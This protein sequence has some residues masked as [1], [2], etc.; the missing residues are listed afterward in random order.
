MVPNQNFSGQLEL[1]RGLQNRTKPHQL[2]HQPHQ[3]NLIGQFYFS[4][5]HGCADFYATIMDFLHSKK[6]IPQHFQMN[7]NKR[8]SVK[9]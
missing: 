4:H 2:F 9:N 8:S 1:D 5:E 3:L 7:L 6:R